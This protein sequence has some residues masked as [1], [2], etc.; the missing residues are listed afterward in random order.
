M[1]SKRDASVS[2][3]QLAICSP[4]FQ[5]GTKSF[6]EVNL[7]LTSLRHNDA[8]TMLLSQ[9]LLLHTVHL[10]AGGALSMTI[11]CLDLALHSEPRKKTIGQGKH[12]WTLLLLSAEIFADLL[13][14]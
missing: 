11:S 3:E 8:F 10:F 1:Q 6:S 4:S 7:S 2:T 12:C 14:A 13:F 5:S 9:P